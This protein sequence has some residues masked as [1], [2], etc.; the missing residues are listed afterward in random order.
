MHPLVVAAL[1][2]TVVMI[3]MA[4]LTVLLY[5]LR[6]MAKRTE[7]TAAPAAGEAGSLEFA[8][9]LVA[10]LAAAA[11]AALD[12]PV[13]LH[14]IHVYRGPA[15]DQWSRAGRMDIMVSHRVEPRR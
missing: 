14:Q 6:R 1:A 9:E 8:P 4:T 15:A 11:A 3:G 2:F 5:G 13:V 12:S 10:V 7:R